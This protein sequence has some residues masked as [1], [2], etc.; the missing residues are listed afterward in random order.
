MNIL[1]IGGSGLFGRKTVIHLLGDSEV[2]GVISLDMV[3]PPE[4]LFKAIGPYRDR[5]RFIRGDVSEIEDVLK[6]VKDYS[7]D[8]IINFAYILTGAFEQSPRKAIKVNTLGMCNVFET[9]RLMGIK[10]VVYA[11]SVGVYGTQGEYG[12]RDVNEDD[13]PHPI[14]AY[15]VTKQLA[16]MLAK[17]YHDL[18][19]INFSGLRPFLGYGHGGTFPPII[20]LFSD[21]VSLPAQGKTFRTEMDGNSLS[22]LSSADDVAALTGLLIKAP[23]SPHPVYNVASQPAS[24][25]DIASAIKK[26]LSD[27]EIEFGNQ[28]QPA[29]AARNGL[30]WKVSCERARQDFG[31]S[32][33][34]LEKAVLLHINDARLE[35]GLDPVTGPGS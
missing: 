18:Y 10:R 23:S 14:N 31:F 13:I 26:Y 3:P 32:L 30:P 8:R 29:E 24:M 22:A 6:C 4:W 9:A 35:A 7:V 1:V 15:G 17:Q 19:S 20:K 28:S 16:E 27:T 11:S 21:L 34:P 25:R 33:L 5:F 2:S 12:D